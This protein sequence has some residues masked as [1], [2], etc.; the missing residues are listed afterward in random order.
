MK[1]QLTTTIAII[2]LASSSVAI[3]VATM[4]WGWGLTP[5]NWWIII[6]LGVFAQAVIQLLLKAVS[7]DK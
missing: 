4:I 5:K 7:N 2:F 3:G 6:G 1:R